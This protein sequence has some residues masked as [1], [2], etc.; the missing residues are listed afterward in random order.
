MAKK[1]LVATVDKD[2]VKSIG[3]LG[4]QITKTYGDIMIPADALLELQGRIIPTT[5]SLDIA[6]SGGIPEGVIVSMASPP[7]AGKTTTCLTAIAKAQRLYKKRCFY[8]D[9]E[10]RLRT[11][12]LQCI[13]GLVWTEEQEKETGIPRLQIIRSTEG[14]FLT[15]EKYLNIIDAIIKEV[16]GA[17][18]VLD[19]V[20]ALCTDALLG[21]QLGE[22]KRMM[23]IPSLMYD[24]LR[25]QCQQLPVMNSNLVCITHLQ[26]NPTAYGNPLKVVGG[27]ALEFFASIRMVCYSSKEVPDDATPKTGKHTKFKITASALGSPGGEATIFVKYGYG[28][29]RYE[30]IMSVAEEMGVGIVRA[31][32][33]YTLSAKDKED[34][35]VQ[36]QAKVLKYLQENLDFTDALEKELRAILLPEK[37]YA[38]NAVNKRGPE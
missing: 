28:C 13:P 14:N 9:V 29:D 16:K 19:S 24:F 30:D 27:N 6:L 1:E 22:S 12:L 31:G 20:A 37:N 32:A 4:D 5:L 21:V 38:N 10:G 11:D 3:T 35:R 8:A 26:A 34:V 25:K 17:F 18:I 2:T 23:G 15:A 36:G 7:K 33:W